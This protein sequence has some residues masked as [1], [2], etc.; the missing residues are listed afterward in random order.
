MPFIKCFSELQYAKSLS[1]LADF[2]RIRSGKE[3]H[4]TSG[5]CIMEITS[6]AVETTSEIENVSIR[7]PFLANRCS[8]KMGVFT[9]HSCTG[10]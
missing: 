10:I 5:Y 1:A 7:E 8:T 6:E 4:V 2:K 3:V 9:V